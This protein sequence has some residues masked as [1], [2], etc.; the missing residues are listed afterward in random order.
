MKYVFEGVNPGL[1]DTG[2]KT[3][4]LSIAD[5]NGNTPTLAYAL[6]GGCPGTYVCRVT[7]SLGRALTITYAGRGGRLSQ[8]SDWTGRQ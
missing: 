8:V 3:R 2:L 6:T 1:T 4:L 7:D 5:R